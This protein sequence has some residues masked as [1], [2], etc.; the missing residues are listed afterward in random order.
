MSNAPA[1]DTVRIPLPELHDLACRV[2]R[3]QGLSQAHA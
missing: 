3:R 2:L 1:T